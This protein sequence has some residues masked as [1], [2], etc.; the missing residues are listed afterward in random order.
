MRKIE[1]YRHFLRCLQIAH[2]IPGRVRFRIN[3]GYA[4]G[5]QIDRQGAQDFQHLLDSIPGVKSIRLNILALSCIV[6]YDSTVIPDGAWADLLMG[7][8]TPAAGCLLD[9]LEARYQQFV[10]TDQSL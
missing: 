4:G 7:A 1:Q 8:D 5:K 3:F 9:I 10:K 6:E 2:Q